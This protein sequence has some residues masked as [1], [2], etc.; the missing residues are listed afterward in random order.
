MPLWFSSPYSAPLLPLPTQGPP[1]STYT[2]TH[3]HTHSGSTLCSLSPPLTDWHVHKRGNFFHLERWVFSQI[4]SRVRSHR[5]SAQSNKNPPA[6]HIQNRCEVASW[7]RMNT[8]HNNQ[9][10]SSPILITDQSVT[11]MNSLG[12]K[13]VK[14][15]AHH[16]FLQVASFVQPAV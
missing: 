8:D 2:H 3:T 10:T 16:I 6:R 5:A 14:K 1:T 9:T 11:T 4:P 15:N 7:Q 12:H 13:K